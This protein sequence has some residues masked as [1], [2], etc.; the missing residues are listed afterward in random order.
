MKKYLELGTILSNGGR[1]YVIEKVLGEGGF[2][3]TYKAY[4]ESQIENNVSRRYYAIKEY[5]LTDSCE[6]NER[7]NGIFYSNPVKDRV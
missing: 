6:R 4:L 7:T 2:G 1:N 3:I 5:F